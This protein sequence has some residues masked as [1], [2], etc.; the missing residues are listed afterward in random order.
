MQIVSY[1]GEKI[2][3]ISELA[4]KICAVL[5][6]LLA[7]NIFY[8]VVARYLFSNS[9]IFMQE[10]EWHIFSIIFLL[11]TGYALKHD[12][13]VRVDLIYERLSLKKKA[14]INILGVLIFVMP[15]SFLIL[16]TSFDFVSYAY[17]IN[18]KSP[19]PGGMPYRFII[20]ALIPFAF[21]LTILQG[22]ATIIRQ[23]E[24]LQDKNIK[25]EE[26]K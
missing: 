4:G 10:L 18:E 1:I 13:H 15:L 6:V 20:K 9:S 17:E 26:S 11:S 8:D 2:E 14:V 24:I 5:V 25:K 19:D 16:Y 12:A 3:T 21:L 22:I 7:I 23:V